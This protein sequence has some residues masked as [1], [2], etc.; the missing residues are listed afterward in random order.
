MKHF[1]AI[2]SALLFGALQM[3]AQSIGYI[4]TEKILAE[5][6][7]YVNAQAQLES[8]SKKY[9]Q[10]IESG[11]AKIEAV[12]N[13]YQSQKA[14]LSPQARQQKEN[15]IISMEDSVKELQNR[16]FGQDGQMQKKSEELLSPIKE[17][18]DLAVKKVALESKCFIV[19]DIA[20]MQGVAYTD[21]A[22]DLSNEV[23]RHLGL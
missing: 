22:Y 14:Y 23:I 8:L 2:V 11:Y 19:F 7:A 15:E 10:E 21:P 16:Y 4:N 12:Y 5:I 1:F 18:V 20:S 3:N 9:Q 6:P 13:N 17:M